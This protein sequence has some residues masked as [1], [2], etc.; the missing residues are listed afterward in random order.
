M[1]GPSALSRAVVHRALRT[2]P[3]PLL[4]ENTLVLSDSCILAPDDQGDLCLMFRH[5]HGQLS[6]GNT[7]MQ[8]AAFPGL[9]LLGATISDILHDSRDA[10]SVCVP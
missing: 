7:H 4:G 6:A 8:A 9:S 10:Q 3:Y 1:M 2:V 5:V